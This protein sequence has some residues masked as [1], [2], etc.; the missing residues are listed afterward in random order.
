MVKMRLT[1]RMR[2][3]HVNI[4]LATL[5]KGVLCTPRSFLLLSPDRKP[6]DVSSLGALTESLK[7]STAVVPMTFNKECKFDQEHQRF[8]AER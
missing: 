6:S 4:G 5:R 8:F 3:F 2:L 1:S 7:A